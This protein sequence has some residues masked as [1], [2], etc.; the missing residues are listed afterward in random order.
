MAYN[1]LKRLN[2]EKEY[3]NK[4]CFFIKNHDYPIFKSLI[5][6][7]YEYALTIYKIQKCDA[8]AHNPKKFEK[9]K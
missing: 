3:I 2:F 6:D 7:N 5:N 1:I 9:R 4:I 8:L